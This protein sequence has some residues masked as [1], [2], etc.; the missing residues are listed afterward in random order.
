M[1]IE[2]LPTGMIDSNC[3]IVYDNNEGIIIDAGVDTSEVLNV[4][5]EKKINIKYIVLTHIHIDHICHVDELREKTGAKVLVHK[6]DSEKLLDPMLNGSG[7]FG[8]KT[9]FKPAD[10]VL[11]DNDEI[12]AGGINFKIIHTPGHSSGSI[13]IKGENNLF[14]GDTL[15][16]MGRGRTDLG[17]GNERDILS[18]IKKRLMTFDDETVVYPGHGDSTT[19]GAEKVFY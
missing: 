3:Y 12:S 4:L 16:K 7:F 6:N 2:C 14:T 15:F 13:C 5:N 11:E 18:S 9:S 1:L 19:I 10:R 8:Q 17:D